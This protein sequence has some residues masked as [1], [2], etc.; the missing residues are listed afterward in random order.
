MHIGRTQ[1]GSRFIYTFT[2]ITI[3][4]I[5]NPLGWSQSLYLLISPTR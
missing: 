3:W 2:V 1:V 5:Y 4:V